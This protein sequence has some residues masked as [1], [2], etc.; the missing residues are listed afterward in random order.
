MKL[1]DCAAA[2]DKGNT[3]DGAVS[4]LRPPVM[5]FRKSDFVLQLKIWQKKQIFKVLALL[6]DAEKQCKQTG[7]PADQI[8]EYALMQIASAAKKLK[9]A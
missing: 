8:G 7:K 1:L 3:A 5:W 2:V 4:A 9:A 6:Y